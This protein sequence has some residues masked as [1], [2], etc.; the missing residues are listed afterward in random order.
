MKPKMTFE[1]LPLKEY[2]LTGAFPISYGTKCAFDLEN[3]T[4]QSLDLNRMVTVCIAV[5][6][7]KAF[8][9]LRIQDYQL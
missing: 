4:L 8:A 9:V 5:Y 6:T 1:V 7:Q 3:G 2:G